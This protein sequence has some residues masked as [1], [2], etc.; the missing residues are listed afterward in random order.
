MG[1]MLEFAAIEIPNHQEQSN[2]S[3]SLDIL[4]VRH[5]LFIPHKHTHDKTPSLTHTHTSAFHIQNPNPQTSNLFPT[6]PTP[7]TFATLS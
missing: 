4:M 2:L 1:R 3:Y 5:A 7:L 6:S